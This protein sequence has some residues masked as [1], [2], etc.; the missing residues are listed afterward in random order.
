MAAVQ[1]EMGKFISVTQTV[2]AAVQTEKGEL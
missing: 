2:T 1:T